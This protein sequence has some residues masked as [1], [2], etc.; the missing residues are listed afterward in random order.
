MLALGAAD[1]SLWARMWNRQQQQ[2]TEN[3]GD[4]SAQRPL[5]FAITS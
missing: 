3:E 2:A 1:V 4:D 5:H